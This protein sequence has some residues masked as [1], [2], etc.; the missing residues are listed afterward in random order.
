MSRRVWQFAGPRWEGTPGV[1]DGENGG[2]EHCLSQW[3]LW[4]SGW[5]ETNNLDSEGTTISTFKDLN[6]PHLL[7][8]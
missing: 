2:V 8:I 5:L 4:G 1:G 7:P 3:G 6:F